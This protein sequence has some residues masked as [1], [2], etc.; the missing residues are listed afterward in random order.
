[1]HALTIAAALA[2]ANL[3]M[4]NPAPA[5]PKITPAPL[6]LPRGRIIARQDGLTGAE[7][8]DCNL[9]YWGL[10]A[11]KP[12]AATELVSWMSENGQTDLIEDLMDLTTID[13]SFVTSFCPTATI[14]PPASLESAY[15]SYQSAVSSWQSSV[16]D[17]VSSIAENCGNPYSALVDI[18]IM[19][20]QGES[21]TSA[22]KI[23]IEAA[24]SEFAA[25]ST[26]G[27]GGDDEEETAN[28]SAQPQPSPSGNANGNGNA[29]SGEASTTAGA[30]PSSTQ[31]TGGVPRATG[32]VAAAAAAAVGVVGVV[33]VL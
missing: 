32:F 20:V 5:H 15:S 28:T 24:E 1:M 16:N 31:S 13:D 10:I 11:E 23:V 30:V 14:T 6:P 21:C 19:S 22:A 9:A 2:G 33:A 26:A 12:T 18:V 8:E 17:E 25:T 3:V 4:A 27:N 7:E 29:G